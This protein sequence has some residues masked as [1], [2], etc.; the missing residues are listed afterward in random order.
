MPGPLA[1]GLQ[2]TR[3]VRVRS[4]DERHAADDVDPVRAKRGNL[5]RIIRQQ[6]DSRDAELAEQR[7]CDVVRALVLAE[8]ELTIGVE[9]VET[10]VLQRIRAQL[11]R[12]DRKS[13]V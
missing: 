10:I 12:E 2:V 7:G 11:V 3:V 4:A 1:L 5:L 9:R 8:A 6:L 13:D